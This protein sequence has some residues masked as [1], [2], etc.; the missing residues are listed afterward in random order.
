MKK[1]LF[2]IFAAALCATMSFSAT[3]ANAKLPE[4]PNGFTV[5][6]EDNVA[7]N[8][9]NDALA[10]WQHYFDGA[11]GP[12]GSPRGA[13]YEDH[14][15]ALKA[16]TQG[17]TGNAMHFERKSSVGDFVAYSYFMGVKPNQN[18][19]VQAYVKAENAEGAKLIFS[20]QERIGDAANRYTTNTQELNK[21]GTEVA[22]FDT[23]AEDGWKKI[24]FNYSSS[25]T[26][27]DA[28]IKIQALGVG[29]MYVDDIT[30]HESNAVSNTN[31]FGLQS[32]GDLN[33]GA[34]SDWQLTGMNRMTTANI[35]A[36]SSDGDGASLKLNDE[37][38]KTYFGMLPKEN[39]YKLSFKY[40]RLSD[41]AGDRLVM[42]LD[43]FIYNE[44][45]DAFDRKWDAGVINAGANE[46]TLYEYE[47]SSSTATDANASDI[48][49]MGIAAYGN[50][51][52]DELAITCTS[53]DD[54][55]QY[56]TNGH[57]SGAY[58]AG[59]SG[60][61]NNSNI[62]RLSDGS[63]AIVLGNASKDNTSGNAGY[64]DIDTTGL[65]QGKTYTLKFDYISGSL[66]PAVRIF[67]GTYWND[68]VAIY[69][70]ADYPA[71]NIT[72]WT[73]KQVTFEAGK[74]VTDNG[75]KVTV[76]NS[77]RLEFYGS[78]GGW[79]T[80]L[81]NFSIVDEE[82]NEYITN[83][84]LV[85]PGMILGEE[86]IFNYG[87]FEGDVNYKQTSADWTFEGNAYVYGLKFELL[88]ESPT[89]T[90]TTYKGDWKIILK[91]KDGAPA[92][93]LSKEI[94]AKTS[95]VKIYEKMYFGSVKT[96]LLV[97][98]TEIE[99]N[100]D[101]VFELPE[102]TKSF[103]IKFT[104][105]GEYA[106][107]KYVYVLGH[108]HDAA[109]ADESGYKVTEATC[110]QNGGKCYTCTS[111]GYDVYVEKTNALGHNY[112]EKHL[113]ATCK[114]GY[115]KKVCSRC[116]DEKDVTVIPATG[117]HDYKT[118]VDKEATCS[119]TG[120]AHEEC[121]ICDA[122]GN[123]S[124]IPKLDHHFE[125]GTCTVCGATDPDYKPADSSQGGGDAKDS[126]STVEEPV[127]KGCNSSLGGGE[128]ALFAAA[129]LAVGYIFKKKEN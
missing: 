62:A 23:D 75:D 79:P 37:V 26:A 58:L 125:N 17:H 85:S 87:T 96:T 2:G 21:P 98:D 123:T 120:M 107:F 90:E 88:Y 112:E 76:R 99:G 72:N 83:K 36:D 53:S 65:E 49:W 80:Y 5:S 104:G 106:A 122:R 102:G 19:Y 39:N 42:V 27:L 24:S 50:Y 60:M 4:K 15:L 68:Q 61:A 43:N 55:M 94:A 56:L 66:T 78:T 69:A 31:V 40:K 35:A 110:T 38:Y 97:G 13:M 6:E 8:G 16:T 103:R 111:C 11:I 116:G 101:D 48:Q 57:F 29:D 92:T 105:L 51:L 47:F 22:N 14:N 18:Y 74:Q 34:T 20:I 113:D 114:D 41:N 108:T 95:T 91:S 3:I 45:K 54:Q 93:A 10:G 126:S 70:D 109:P 118:V 1:S 124:I 32:I 63:N 46:W 71:A 129:L 121:K 127:E 59:Y 67:Y 28:R 84:T 81:R 73:T 86:N 64:L 115:D 77:T 128:V 9:A 30:V 44:E 82:G 33:N 117:E 100:A 7:I 52:I 25:S 89:Y 119:Q 12:D